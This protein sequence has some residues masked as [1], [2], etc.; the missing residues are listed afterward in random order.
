MPTSLRH[1]LR[2]L[3]RTPAF[4]FA[5]ILT[6]VL[7]IGSLAAA[8]AIVYGVLL[9][10]LRYGHPDRLV[11]VGINPRTGD[12]RRMQQPPGVF[13]TYKRFARHLEDVAFYRVGNANILTGVGNDEA[14]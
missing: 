7:G 5:A 3:E 1:A 13:Y 2:S 14:E 10:P 9:A 6:L 12:V 11:S 8:F 4:T